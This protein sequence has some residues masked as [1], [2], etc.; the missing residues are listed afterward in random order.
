MNTMNTTQYIYIAFSVT[1][2][3][4]LQNEGSQY[5]EYDIF[6]NFKKG[7][8]NIFFCHVRQC[9]IMGLRACNMYMISRKDIYI[10]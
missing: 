10:S 7:S 3:G 2:T 8:M 9:G 5:Y 6:H 1:H 4:I